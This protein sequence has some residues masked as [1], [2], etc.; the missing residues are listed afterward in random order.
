MEF[1]RVI[2]DCLAL[3]DDLQLEVLDLVGEAADF[4]EETFDA[5]VSA[6]LSTFDLCFAFV[7]RVRVHLALLVPVLPQLLQ[8]EESLLAAAGHTARVDA[9]EPWAPHWAAL[10]RAAYGRQHLLL[11]P[12]T[13]LWSL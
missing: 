13:F 2:S 9:H 1:G 4:L 11:G 12:A 3:L 6:D 10:A 8:V 7:A 5:V